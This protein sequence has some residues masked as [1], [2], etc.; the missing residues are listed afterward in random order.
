MFLR[1]VCTFVVLGTLSAGLWPFH[2]PKNGIRWAD[3]GGLVFGRHGSVLSAQRVRSAD[4]A[5][6]GP[7]SLEIWLQPAAVHR[8]GTILAVYE[9]D[10]F[11]ILFALRQ[12]V[13]D[14]AIGRGDL[15]HPQHVRYNRVYA[16]DVFRRPDPVLITITSGQSGTTV[17]SNTILVKQF[18]RLKLS[19]RD[20]AGQL[21]LG[22]APS[23]TDS[24][25]G[26]VEGLAIYSRELAM[27]DVKRHYSSWM[28]RSITPEEGTVALYG[29]HEGA[30]TVVHNQVD[31]TANLVI[32]LRF[33]VPNKPFLERPWDEFY[34]GWSYWE[35]I[36]VNILGFVPLG[37]IFC[38]LCMFQQVRRPVLSVI[39]LG[40]AVSLTIEALQGFLPTRDSGMTDLF[41]NTLGAG[42][43]AFVCMKA[44]A[45]WRRA[46]RTEAHS[47]ATVRSQ[48]GRVPTA[49][50]VTG[51]HS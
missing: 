32:P 11:A 49:A 51:G 3:H 15:D 28:E 4:L 45:L 26:K 40:F 5:G 12:S 36:A 1:S 23:T 33:V 34:P 8:A 21:I 13:K 16:E 24:W 35:N 42:L 22:N 10:S 50:M 29:F 17:Y 20:F 25:S 41:T 9:A 30:G 19:A 31:Q 48:R 37:F 39:A 18:P 14:L 47:P 6:N 44:S 43:G 38:A 27:G 2:A 46:R 7:S